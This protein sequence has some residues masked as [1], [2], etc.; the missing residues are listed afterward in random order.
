MP[1]LK[2]GASTAAKGVAYVLN[3]DYTTQADAVFIAVDSVKGMSA[4]QTFVVKQKD[5]EVISDSDG[6]YFVMPAIDENGD[7]IEVKVDAET[8]GADSADPPTKLD[9]VG[10]VQ[11]IGVVSMSD[12]TKDKNDIYTN[13]TFDTP[14]SS[15]SFSN[16]VSY[17]KTTGLVA[18]ANGVIGLG[19]DD[20]AAA[21]YW[22]YTGNTNFY[23]VSENFKTLTKVSASDIMTD[24][25]DT[26][27]FVADDDA[28]ASYRVVK[29]VIV[30][31]VKD[32]STTPT[33]TPPTDYG[34]TVGYLGNSDGSKN[35]QILIGKLKEDGTV[36]HWLSKTE[37]EALKITA[38]NVYIENKGEEV[39]TK[40]GLGQE[41]TVYPVATTAD[42]DGNGYK[43]QFDK[44][45]IAVF[46]ITQYDGKKATG[47]NVG[48]SSA[49]TAIDKIG[50]N[51]GF[52]KIHVEKALELDNVAGETLKV[53]IQIGG[54]TYTSADVYDNIP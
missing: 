34:Y 2:T 45:P 5:H 53:W 41:G 49:T 43:Y 32:G 52:M 13:A 38:D 11:V 26:V 27:Y 17:Y 35:V 4:N 28:T 6:K 37:I 30:Q 15:A 25:N 54:K 14:T 31:K 42:T 23:E 21:I 18:P 46:E 22:A 16:G 9:N 44:S 8:L 12:V 50:Y 36:D 10:D 33:P 3:S 1:S 19:D 48:T 47:S 39:K 40:F 20:K 51:C 24:D 7:V 29:T